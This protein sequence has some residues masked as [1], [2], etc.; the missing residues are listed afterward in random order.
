MP[1]REA[2]LICGRR[3]G[4]SRLLSLIAVYLACFYDYSKFL[5]PGETGVLAVIAADRRQARVILRYCLGFLESI[6]LLKSK[7]VKADAEVI[8]LTNNIVLEI[9]T[10]RI[11]APRGRTFIGVLCDELAFWRD[12]NSSH[13]DKDV[14]DAVRPGLIT[15]PTSMLLMASSPYAKRGVLYNTYRR[16]FANNES[17]TLVWQ[18]PTWTM[19]PGIARD[20]P[21]MTRAF[22]DDPA[23]A[24]AE[25]GAE[26]RSDIDSFVSREVIDAN[27]VFGR[28]ELPPLHRYGESNAGIAIAYKAFVDPS[29]G[30]SDSMTLAVSHKEGDIAVLDAVR[31]AHPPFSPEQTVAEFAALLLTYGIHSVMGDR[32]GG[33][34]PREQFRKH[35]IQYEPA[36]KP[37]SEIYKELLPLLNSRRVELL[38]INRLNTQLAGL[39]RRT[40]RGGRDSIDHAPG[41]HDDVINVVA[42]ALVMV[43]SKPDKLDVWRR[44]AMPGAIWTATHP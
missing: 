19:N 14:V 37:K 32:Y 42:G 22:D 30:S 36:D 6:P 18:A 12:E 24:A 13:P 39:E 3:S 2:S 17:K 1:F 35:G 15:I 40:A 23:A 21:T 41:A 25:Y 44:L 11:A 33:E 43:A 38:D 28:F 8:Q 4:K 5:V 27:T 20:G 31:E 10:G 7:I 26:F 16:H 34:W 29:G 9:H